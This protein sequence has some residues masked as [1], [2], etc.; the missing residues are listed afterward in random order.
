MPGRAFSSG[1][2]PGR[3]FSSGNRFAIAGQAEDAIQD[4][5]HT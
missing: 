2:M 4:V 1:N 3:A 5:I